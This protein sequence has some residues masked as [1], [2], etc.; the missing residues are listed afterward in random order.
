ME[1]TAGSLFA[2]LVV[3]SI[4]FALYLYGKRQARV[5]QLVT[6]VLMMVFP[7]FVTGVVWMSGVAV[8]LLAALWC[9]CRSGL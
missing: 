6:G 8:A 9:A 3:S 4:G 1:L 2:M 7:Y 5:P